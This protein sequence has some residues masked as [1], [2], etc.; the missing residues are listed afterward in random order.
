MESC[1]QCPEAAIDA[2]ITVQP[3]CTKAI[4]DFDPF[5]QSTF[6]TMIRILMVVGFRAPQTLVAK[7]DYGN[8]V[9]SSLFCDKACIYFKGF[10]GSV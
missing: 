8:G 2:C 9:L 1:S 6:G 10:K 3:N 7:S 5:Q 4:A